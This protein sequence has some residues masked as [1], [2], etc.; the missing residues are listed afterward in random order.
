MTLWLV[1]YFFG[2][3]FVGGFFVTKSLEILDSKKR[4]ESSPWANFIFPF[5]MNYWGE[6]KPLTTALF[7]WP[8]FREN[9]L[10]RSVYI[11]ANLIFWF[12]RPLW[13]ISIHLPILFGGDVIVRFERLLDW[14]K[15]TRA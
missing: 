3:G 2:A 7:G 8:W 10:H 1:V 14:R 4:F 9:G 6:P 5:S 15:R 13:I 11:Y 12:V